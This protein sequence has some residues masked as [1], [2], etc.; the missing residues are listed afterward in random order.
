MI[1]WVDCSGLI[2]C[3]APPSFL[4]AALSQQ[5]FV[6][7]S[8]SPLLVLSLALL[9]ASC[10]LPWPVRWVEMQ[11]IQRQAQCRNCFSLGVDLR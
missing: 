3:G 11:D 1:R 7:L 6:V 8:V 5:D 2:I 4:P 10:L 9:L